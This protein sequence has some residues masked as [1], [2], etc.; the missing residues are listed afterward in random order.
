MFHKKRILDIIIERLKI[1][2]RDD[3]VAIYTTTAAQ[4]L[5]LHLKRMTINFDKNVPMVI[6]TSGYT[7]RQHCEESKKL[8]LKYPD[9]IEIR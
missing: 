4:I 3:A 8:K 9:K 1:T 5:R 2:R 6:F 7:N